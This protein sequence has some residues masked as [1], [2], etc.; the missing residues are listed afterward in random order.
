VEAPTP[1]LVGAGAKKKVIIKK[2][3]K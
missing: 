2:K 3:T 1:P